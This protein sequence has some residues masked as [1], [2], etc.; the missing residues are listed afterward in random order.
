MTFPDGTTLDRD[1]DVTVPAPEGQDINTDQGQL[2]NPADAIKNKGDMPDGTKYTWK[3]EP[4]VTTPGDHTGIVEVTFPDGTTYEVTVNVH[5]NAVNNNANAD[6]GNGN[7]TAPQADNNT[8]VT[9]KVAAPANNNKQSANTT[10]QLPQTGNEA[11]E[12]ASLVG[13]GLASV[14]SLFGLGGLRK[15]KEADK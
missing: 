11:N 13:L 5:V 6:N 2:P 14:A 8:T 4:D 3:Q 15:K 1:V 10:K 9:N 7:A 12:T